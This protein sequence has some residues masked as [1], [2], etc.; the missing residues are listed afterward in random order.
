MI[1]S[2]KS[3]NLRQS[4]IPMATDSARVEPSPAKAPLFA[5]LRIHP[6]LT[7]YRR[8]TGQN[9]PPV[10]VSHV[11]SPPPFGQPNVLGRA[12]EELSVFASPSR[13]REDW[14]SA[15]PNNTDRHSISGKTRIKQRIQSFADS[16]KHWTEVPKA[17]F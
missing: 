17:S 5:P 14:H 7:L 13:A 15:T 2:P 16:R 1:N 6:I 11:A 4:H 10:S 3:R 8:R 9:Q 12:S